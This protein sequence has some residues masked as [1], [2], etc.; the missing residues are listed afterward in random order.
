[1]SLVP[2]RPARLALG[3]LLGCTLALLPAVGAHAEGSPNV[4]LSVQAPA[5]VLY[6]ANATVTLSA[7][8]PSGQPYGYNLSY[9]TVLPSGISYVAGSTHVGG[10]TAADP[11]TIAGEPKAGETT[12]IWSNVGD[13]S[14]ASHNT[15]TFEVAHSTTVYAVGSSYTVQAGAY[16][17][18]EPRYLPKF[19]V[20]GVPEGPSSTSYTGYATGSA[21]TTLSA[22]EITQ[23]EPAGELL[24]G[25]HDHQVTYK[26][27][28]SNTKVNATGAAVVDE[29]LPADLEY[30]GCGGPGVDNTTDA[31]TNPGSA[32]EYPGSGPIVV[33]ALGGCIAPASVETVD[34]DPDGGGPEPTG[35]YTHVQFDLGTLAAGETRSFEFRAAVP[36]RENT[37]TWSAKEPTAAS[38]KQA[39][40][41]DNNAGAETRDGESVQTYAQAKGEYNKTTPVFAENHLTRVAKDIVTEKSA[42]SETLAE[43]QV[44]VWTLHVSS[45][46]YRYNTGVVVTDTVP[47]GLCPLASPNLTTSSE[48]EPTG[49]AEDEPSFPYASAVEQENGTWTLVWNESTDAA[50]KLIA[51]NDTATITYATRTRTHYQSGHKAAGPILANDK[52][53]N[54]V[55]AQASTNVVCA[56]DTDCAGG[57]E[58]PIDHERPLS[59]PVSASA[60]AAQSAAGPTIS[61][62]IAKSGAECLSD[63]YIE[64][65]PVYHPGDLICW[66][67]TASFPVATNTKGLQVTDF[68]PLGVEFDAAFNGGKGE[69]ATAA[70]TLPGTTFDDAEAKPTEPGGVLSWTLPES[71]VV[72]N[73][74]QRFQRVYATTAILPKGVAPGDLQGN[75]MK[76]ANVNSPG[77]SFAQRAEADFKLQFPQLSLAKQVVEVGGKTIT[78][79][80]SATV[81]GGQE[82][83]FALT[84]SNSGEVAAG[85]VEVWEQLPEA[86]TCSAVTA[87]SNEGECLS[88]HMIGWGDTGLGQEQVT[89]GASGKTVLHFTV[90]VPAQLDPG[91]TLEDKAGV[92]QYESATNLATEYRYVPGENIDAARD[93]EANAAAANAH[94]TLKSEE[95]K[96]VKTHTSS[97]VETGNSAAQATIGEG[98]TFE[99]SATIPA[100]T[101]LS[102]RARLSDPSIPTARLA[103]EASSAEALVNGA[104]A[105]AGFTVENV[106]GSPVV[107]VPE[108]YE[109]PAAATVTVT[110]RFRATVTNV[111]ANAHGSEIA[112]RGKLAWT[113]P[114]AGAQTRE[115]ETRV[116]LVE[117]SISLSESNNAGAGAVHGGQ[118]VE[119]AIVLKN[120]AGAST[121]FANTALD[122]IPSGLIPSNSKG[123]PLGEGETTADGGV[124]SATKRTITWSLESLAGGGEHTFHYLAMV[125]ESPVSASSLTDKVH[126]S[127]ESL[128]GHSALA[129]TAANAPGSTK[130]GYEASAETTLEVQGAAIAKSSD[131]P[132]ATI[133]HRIAYTLKVTLPAHVVA[134]DETVIDTLP[135][136]VDFDEFLS[137][138]C[139]SGCPPEAAPT[140]QT[141]KPEVTAAGTTTVAWYLGNLSSTD[142]ARTITIVYRA[143]VRETHRSGSARIAAGATIENSALVYYNQSARGTFEAEHIPAPGS[144]DQKTSAVSTA[145][146]VVEPALALAK[147]AS[148]DGGP[149]SKTNPTVSDGDTI[150]YR[151]K[152]TNTGTGPAYDALVNDTPAHALVEV[153][154]VANAAASVTKAW[155]EA[156][157]EIAWQLAGP[158]A[159]GETVTLEYKTKLRAVSELQAGEQI[160]N[161]ASV[162][163]YFGVAQAE[164][165]EGHRNYAGETIAY[166]EYNGPSTQLTATLALP[167]ITVQKTTAASGFPSSANAEVGQAFG[168]RVVVKNTS[169]A[170]AKSVKVTDTLPAN[171]EYVAG[172][173]S[174]APGGALAPVVSGTLAGGLTLTWS[175]SIELAAGQSTVVTYQAKPTT[176]AAINPGTGTGHPNVNS[177]RAAVLDAAGNGGDAEGP[178][179]AG[180]AQAQATLLVP[181][182]QVSKTPAKATVVAGEGDSYAIVVHNAGEG[183]AREV[184]L[185]DTLPAGMTYTPGSASATPST[186]FSETA[187]S[188]SAVTWKIAEIQPGASVEVTVGVGV[189]ASAGAGE[190]TNEVAV[191]SS[192]QPTP[193]QARGT[194]DVSDSADVRAEKSVLGGG[195]AVPGT[196]M[197]YVLGASN[198]GPSQARAVKLTDALP[199]G[200]SYVS[201]T[202]GCSASAGTVTCEAGTLEPGQS[203]S[204]QV[205]VAVASSLTGPIENTVH[206]QG[207]T[208]DPEPANNAA[209]VEVASK[210]S[211]NVKLIKTALTPEVLNGQQARFALVVS[212]EGP[213]DA[214]ETQLVDML[215]AGL[216]F[217]SAS[218][219]TCNAV[220]QEVTCPL[221]ALASGASATIEVIAQ[222]NGL[223]TDVNNASVSSTTEDPEPANNSA[224]ASVKVAAAAELV[225]T[226]TVT[227][228][229]GEQPGAA[230]Y[231]LTLTNTGPD[232]AQNT[233]ITDTLPP[234]VSYVS[235]TAGCTVSGQTLTCN[236]GEVPSGATRTIE[237]QV[238]VEAAAAGQTLSNT[239]EAKS[240]TGEPDLTNNVAAVPIKTAAPPAPP[241]TSGTSAATSTA[242][243][244][245]PAPAAKTGV[246]VS[247]KRRTRVTL[248]KT[249]AE[250]KVAPGG[251][252]HYALTVRD[253]G[254]QAARHV[255]VCD[256]LPQ[257]TTVV[258]RGGGKLAQ[259][260]LCFEVGTLNPG[261]RRTFTVVLRANSD[262]ARAIVNRANAAGSNFAT[263]RAHTHT[264]VHAAAVAPRRESRVT[265]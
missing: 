106:S 49:K 226:Q 214:L 15:L 229:P 99:V 65:T 128:T 237:I 151:L 122:T 94:A 57:G 254:R 1:M 48:C 178:F 74:G 46:E 36:L 113:N 80:G 224:Q 16:V 227:P 33:A 63:E 61:K 20:A 73:E 92:V 176:A 82:A 25:V 125:Q 217:L 205:V 197:T 177:A 55:L 193:V 240:T 249:V 169:T 146:T 131:S 119:Y 159:V 59:E 158:L 111:E 120:A 66:R 38:G 136:S 90:K 212:N 210:P 42:S 242:S 27:T 191:S 234:G 7:S 247:G 141:Y 185:Q 4:A 194:I 144:F 223:G 148:V 258:N 218:G 209:S 134:Y 64:T 14:P 58:T 11:K 78:P 263:M 133:G 260:R 85:H 236:L 107:V 68:L 108:N 138:T 172:S 28:V 245:A 228:P 184:T 12:L 186:G 173:A 70:D 105:P 103:Y 112:N 199:S 110:L 198:K 168:W 152:V 117:P 98:V 53:V 102:G 204:F 235:N 253:A 162:G 115:A 155:S 170:A 252:L 126:A 93:G 243:D 3:A 132:Q 251:L 174:F 230:T 30:L 164:R 135:D 181:G 175:T 19:S 97:V 88:E 215:P 183:V 188:G 208:P 196:D 256:A 246:S 39:V 54:E 182:L 150:D 130:A 86:I 121:A 261:R 5:S 265:G 89:V 69:A 166:R 45:S 259:G 147:E 257:Q 233:V 51:Q 239:A 161:A 264:P 95:V 18:T 124:W 179:S 87:I 171:W 232:T 180:P 47:D 187:A 167:A 190:M 44:T 9:R 219:A 142:V 104:S 79:A 8:N 154:M 60:S 40:D 220:G 211:A 56:G 77:E 35:V 123:E 101:T 143:S 13:L 116:P 202:A 21:K 32:E 163:G 24:R 137:A 153:S 67:L 26:I 225:L 109:A 6:G 100:G 71:G 145:S 114:I 248:H 84:V 83:R 91:T 34:T 140:V 62:A 129:R 76:F 250:R 195:P 31:P 262:A 222:A 2:R 200:L 189:E 29:W 156:S 238:L 96:L 213:S 10:A 216:T 43:G 17:A 81:K 22:I 244:P 41:L 165:V 149:Y 50:L 160:A 52:I 203:A 139:T 157:P 118:L 231:T 201:A 37:T 192:E 23:A 241:A 72:P 221:G 207:M 127:T 255:R 206:A 75:L